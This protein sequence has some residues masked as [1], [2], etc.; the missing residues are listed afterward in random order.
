MSPSTLPY[1]QLGQA[2]GK[3]AVNV[4]GNLD[5]DTQVTLNTQGMYCR[6]RLYMANG[7]VGLLKLV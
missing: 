3:L 1:V 4:L 5:K 7:G 2:L 6:V